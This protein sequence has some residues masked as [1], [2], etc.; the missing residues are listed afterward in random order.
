MR[1]EAGSMRRECSDTVVCM[2]GGSGESLSMRLQCSGVEWGG[3]L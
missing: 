3:S 1:K 2:C